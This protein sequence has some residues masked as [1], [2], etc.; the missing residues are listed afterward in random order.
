MHDAF[1]KG[2][3]RNTQTHNLI[4]KL[5]WL[6]VK[7][8]FTLEL[9]WVCSEANWAADSL[10]RPE[11]TEHARLSQPAFNRLWKTWG[12]GQV[13]MDLMATD[14]SAQRAPIGGGLIH[15]RLPFSSRFHTNGTVGVDVLSRNENHMPG[16]LR[17]CVCYCFPQPSL[18]VV[19]LAH[20][21]KCE[22]GAVVV[23]PNT[24]ASWFPMIEGAGVRSV[25]IAPQDEDS[26]F[27]R[28]H[29]QRGVKPYTFGR[30]GMRAVEVD[31][32]GNI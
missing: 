30:G 3:S 16:P 24:R 22:A 23:V 2:R 21:S 4:T 19:M 13:D 6:Q 5:F 9:R 12:G 10:T 8:D 29:H 28:V 27:F 11:R 7:E 18:V 26:Q 15:Q 1:K 32:R 31:F 20:I 14:T 17:K 25:Q